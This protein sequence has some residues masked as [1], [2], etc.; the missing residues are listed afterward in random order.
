MDVANDADK[1]YLQSKL[2]A[3]GN[4]LT[5]VAAGDFSN[6]QLVNSVNGMTNQITKDKNVMNA[7]SSTAWLRKQQSVMEKAVADGKS[8]QSNMYDFTEQA[9]RYLS[10]DKVGEKFNGRYTQYTDVKKKAMDTIKALHPDLLKYDIPFK[11]DANGKIDERFYA[12]AMKRYKIEGISEAKIAEA[13][14]ATM[15]PDDLNQLRIDSKYEFRGAGPEQLAQKAKQDYDLQR[16][17]AV[18]SLDLLQIKKATTTDPTKLNDIDDEIEQYKELLGGDGKVGKLDEN[19]YKNVEQARTN[20]DDVKFNIYKDGF[21]KEFANAFKWQTKEEEYVTNPLK[22]QENWVNDMK[23][24]QQVESR[25]RYEFGIT[26]SQAE[27]K[28]AIDAEKLALDKALAYGEDG[29][30]TMLGNETDNKDRGQELFTNHVI[31]TDESIKSAKQGLIDKGYNETEVTSMLNRWNESQGVMSKANIPANAIGLIQDIAKNENYVKQLQYFEKRT[32][33]ESEKEAGVAGV[34][35]SNIKGR[36]N[37]SLK[38]NTGEVIN[39]TPKE[40][41]EI[42]LNE[43]RVTQP[44]SPL[45]V[46]GQDPNEIRGTSNLTVDVENLNAKQRKYVDLVYNNPGKLNHATN[47]KLKSITESYR[48]SARNVKDVY[49]K[50]QKIYTEKMGQSANAFVPQIKVVVNAKGE[51]PPLILP[52]L[53]QLIISQDAKGIE[54]DSKYDSATANSYLTDK[55]IKDTKVYVI[56]DGDNYKIQMKNMSDPDNVQSFK[57][58]G[59]EVEAYL[60]KNYVN[61]NVQASSRMTIGKGSSDINRTNVATNALMQKRF[62]DFPGIMNYQV[63][64][65]LEEDSPGLF[66]PT[67]YV[68]NK[69]G[70]YSA[71]EL[72]GN[73]RLSRVGFDQGRDNL[74]ALNDQVLLAVLKQAYPNFDFDKLEK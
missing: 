50:S 70:K 68:K 16:N 34:I 24:K 2:N 60:G 14:A 1:K 66:I 36:G 72:S 57:V 8:S 40:M 63:T 9:N 12:D 61:K 51:V 43:K 67:V 31:A 47:T 21:V 56:Q 37:I 48:P 59:P 30:W 10:S 46:K 64:A 39:L 32:K 74:N 49:A 41:L 15:T 27:R 38:T 17:S 62:G 55:M 4:N 54:T 45:R 23:F 53:S 29:P 11:M 5:A 3:L 35:N 25:Q 65:K 33:A 42:V 52:R 6:F 71:F 22:Q 58:S 44:T 13:L 69:N 19:F 7:V 73:N 20:P 28:I 26:S 18:A